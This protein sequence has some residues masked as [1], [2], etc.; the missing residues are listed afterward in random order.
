MASE[1]RHLSFQRLL[2]L[3]FYKCLETESHEVNKMLVF[4]DEL[5]I[6]DCL[7]VVNEVIMQKMEQKSK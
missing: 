7:Y 1:M 6:G 3:L 5:N 4:A 2:S